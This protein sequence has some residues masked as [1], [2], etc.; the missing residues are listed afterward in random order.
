MKNRLSQTLT[1][2]KCL[3]LILIIIRLAYE[4]VVKNSCYKFNVQQ[5]SSEQAFD[6]QIYMDRDFISFKFKK[7]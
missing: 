3:L 4:E 7:A 5:L 2:S 6:A 1:V